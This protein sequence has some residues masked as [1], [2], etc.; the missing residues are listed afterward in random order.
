MIAREPTA[1]RTCSIVAVLTLSPLLRTDHVSAATFEVDS[2]GDGADVVLDGVCDADAGAPVECTLRA[3]IAEANNT[4]GPHSIDFEIGGATPHVIQPA[5]GNPLPTV[6]KTVTIDGST[7]SDFNTNSTPVIE[8]DGTNLAAGEDGLKIRLRMHRSQSDNQ[9]FSGQRY[10]HECE[11]RH[12]RRQ[13]DRH[14]RRRNDSTAQR[15][16]RNRD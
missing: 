4:V 12:V 6:N 14:R 8:L 11:Q 16:L 5:V 1:L 2:T 10:L 7:D 9:Q 15:R 13:L 3:A